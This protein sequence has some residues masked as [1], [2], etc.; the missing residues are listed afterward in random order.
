MVKTL[1]LKSACKQLG[2]NDLCLKCPNDGQVYGFACKALPSGAVA[3]VLH[4]NRFARFLKAV[5]LRCGVIACN[6]FDDYPIIE[7]TT[8]SDNT[9]GTLRAVTKLLGI[10]VAED[11]DESFSSKTDLLGGLIPTWTKFVCATSSNERKILSCRWTKSSTLEASTRCRSLHFLVAC[12]SPNHRYLVDVVAWRWKLWGGWK[13]CVV[14]VSMLMLNR[15]W[16]LVSWGADWIMLNQEALLQPWVIHWFWF[17]LMAHTNHQ[18]KMAIWWAKLLSAGWFL[19]VKVHMLLA[20]LSVVSCLGALLRCADW[21]LCCC[22]CKKVSLIMEVWWVHASKV[23]P[24]M[25]RGEHC[26]LGWKRWTS[27]L[28]LWVGSQV[29]QVRATLQMVLRVVRLINF[30]SL[31]E[32][33]L[34]AFWRTILWWVVR[35]SDDWNGEVKIFSH[36]DM[37]FEEMGVNSK[38]TS[39]HN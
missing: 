9:D 35:I 32:M 16:C 22:A 25:L 1:D 26:C 7:L 5:F 13:H 14:K 24:K 18:I 4:F 29:F 6:N 36:E 34:L 38:G 23:M 15:S 10:T 2:L 31:F 17:S 28:L 39:H 30:V 12:S 3:S 27:P 11:K 19:F 37:C 20:E 21:V 8:S 33:N